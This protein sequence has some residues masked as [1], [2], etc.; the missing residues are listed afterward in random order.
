MEF[1]R[2]VEKKLVLNIVRMEGAIHYLNP[3]VE[4]VTLQRREDLLYKKAFLRRCENLKRAETE[5]D[6]LG[7]QVDVLLCLLDKIYRT[8]LH[9]TPALQQ[10]SEVWDILKM[11]E[12]E[13][14]GAARASGK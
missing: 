5:V 11:I 4:L 9:Y 13:L 6:L 7:D 1:K 10:Y 8:L 12:E 14:I 2:K 3:L